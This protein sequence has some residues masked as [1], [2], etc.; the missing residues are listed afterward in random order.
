MTHMPLPSILT[1]NE[2][3]GSEVAHVV[4][5]RFAQFM[6]TV[7]YFQRHLTLPR[8]CVTVNIRLEIWADQPS[9]EAIP[10]SDNFEVICNNP[11]LVETIE[12]EAID[13]SAPGPGGMPAD[14]LRELHGLP[15][16]QPGRGPRDV[17][18]QI[19]T[20]DEYVASSLEG[21]E[22]E[23]L[24]GLKISRTGSGV[25]DGMPTSTNATVAKIDQ[26][27][28]GLRE[29]RMDRDAWHFGRK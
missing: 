6:Q 7:P 16:P 17:G 3:D 29:G 2:L 15:I 21:R 19:V 4:G 28:A 25:I 23:G 26:G 5:N 8:V 18:A 22:V 10:L 24:P 20:S 14:Q 27:R 1:Y 13:S 12:A 9:P 11:V